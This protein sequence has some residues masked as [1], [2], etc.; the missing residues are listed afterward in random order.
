MIKIEAAVPLSTFSYAYWSTV[1]FFSFF[2]CRLNTCH[3]LFIP[4]FASLS[5]TGK[6]LC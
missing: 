2:K 3:F 1:F 6:L 4:L 5:H